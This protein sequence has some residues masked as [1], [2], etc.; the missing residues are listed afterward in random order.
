MAPGGGPALVPVGCGCVVVVVVVAEGVVVV[1]DDVV[2][3]G[4]VLAEVVGAVLD[5]GVDDVD[6]GPVVVVGCGVLL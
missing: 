6:D 2:D 5:V 3:D 1:L 4:G